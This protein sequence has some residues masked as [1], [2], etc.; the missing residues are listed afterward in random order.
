MDM[1]TLL[2]KLVRSNKMLKESR[3]KFK[4]DI[5]SVNRAH[6]KLDDIQSHINESNQKLKDA[7]DRFS[8]L[9]NRL[10][11]SRVPNIDTLRSMQDNYAECIKHYQSLL[12]RA[13]KQ[14][15][16][17][18]FMEVREQNERNFKEVHEQEVEEKQREM[19]VGVDFTTFQAFVNKLPKHYKKKFQPVKEKFQ[20]YAGDDKLMGE[21]EFEIMVNNM[22]TAE[23]LG[24]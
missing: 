21:Q 15:L 3:A 11:A 4:Q 22:A 20:M 14:T 10:D 12:T 6:N 2:L 18:I 13:E 19:E 16:Y 9:G 1:R 24:Y 5:K 17:S 7:Y 23:A 8:R